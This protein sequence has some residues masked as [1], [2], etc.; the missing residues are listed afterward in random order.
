M[1]LK[2]ALLVACTYSQTQ[3]EVSEGYERMQDVFRLLTDDLGFHS[4]QIFTLCDHQDFE[5]NNKYLV[6]SGYFEDMLPTKDNIYKGISWLTSNLQEGD[7]TFF[8]FIGKLYAFLI[9]CIGS[10]IYIFILKLYSI[11]M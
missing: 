8:Y 1:V 9:T 11:T 2:K 5:P 3:F 10:S 7:I 4:Q 6:N